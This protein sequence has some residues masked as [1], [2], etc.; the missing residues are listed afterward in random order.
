M[1]GL[2]KSGGL[3]KREEEILSWEDLIH[4]LIVSGISRLVIFAIPLV[5]GCTIDAPIFWTILEYGSKLSGM[6]GV[7]TDPEK[8]NSIA[9][10]SNSFRVTRSVM[11]PSLRII[12]VGK[13][14]KPG[15]WPVVIRSSSRIWLLS[16]AVLN[17]GYK[18]T[19]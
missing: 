16:H 1:I 18:D 8:C 11:L 6:L 5:T 13:A 7:L 2:G 14:A 15:S 3:E 12:W 19:G 9:I 4:V 17:T 10:L